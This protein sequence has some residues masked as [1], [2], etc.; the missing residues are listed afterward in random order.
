MSKKIQKNYLTVEQQF[1]TDWH[2][3][4][5]NLAIFNELKTHHKALS[6]SDYYNSEWYIS[7]ELLGILHLPLDTFDSENNL[8][9][10]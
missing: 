1:L 8:S 3:A 2:R 5:K 9:K 4:E 6:P 7:N 10:A